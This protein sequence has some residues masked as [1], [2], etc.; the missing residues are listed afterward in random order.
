[1]VLVTGGLVADRGVSAYRGESDIPN[2]C[3]RLDALRRRREPEL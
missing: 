3:D 1:L 2:V